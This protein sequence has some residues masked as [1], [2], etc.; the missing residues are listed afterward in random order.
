MMTLI[1]LLLV[2][3]VRLSV[4][5]RERLY[6]DYTKQTQHEQKTVVS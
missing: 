3:S 1:D 6:S 4:W 2:L 5:S